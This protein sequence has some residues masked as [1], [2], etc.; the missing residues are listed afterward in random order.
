MLETDSFAVLRH[1]VAGC[2]GRGA[3]TK[4]LRSR[5]GSRELADGLV[6]VVVAVAMAS[7][8]IGPA[9]LDTFGTGLAALFSGVLSPD[10]RVETADR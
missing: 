10:P 1:A 9:V 7:T 8:Q 2:P 4:N 5:P 3:D 6:A